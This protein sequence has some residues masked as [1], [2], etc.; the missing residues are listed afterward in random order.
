MR[1]GL[2]SASTHEFRVSLLCPVELTDPKT[3]EV[4]KHLVSI[5]RLTNEVV[6]IPLDKVYTFGIAVGIDPRISGFFT[7]RL[8]L[9]YSLYK[10]HVAFVCIILEVT[11]KPASVV[12][13]DFFASDNRWCITTNRP[14]SLRSR[15]LSEVKDLKQRLVFHSRAVSRKFE[16]PKERRVLC[17]THE[18]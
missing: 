12:Q 1:L 6:S 11:G 18:I 14:S 15:P 8:L 7:L 13:F 10:L 2:P 5:D 9:T 3:G 17:L 4:K 16:E